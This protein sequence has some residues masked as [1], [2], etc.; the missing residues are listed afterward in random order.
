MHSQ[1]EEAMFMSDI[2]EAVPEMVSAYFGFDKAVF[3]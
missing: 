3:N 2:K 1:N